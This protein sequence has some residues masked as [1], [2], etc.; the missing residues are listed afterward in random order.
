MEKKSAIPHEFMEAKDV[1]GKKLR[2]KKN[3]VWRVQ[4]YQFILP[5]V[6]KWG[7]TIEEKK[8]DMDAS[9]SVL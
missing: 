9:F 5:S 8:V 1:V 3:C 4:D 2:Y 6:I 7:E